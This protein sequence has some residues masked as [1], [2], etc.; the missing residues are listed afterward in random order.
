MF[1]ERRHS[2][3]F[4]PGLGKEL[5]AQVQYKRNVVPEMSPQW[6]REGEKKRKASS[7]VEASSV[8]AAKP[9]KLPR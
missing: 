7:E 4:F 8:L 5:A 3:G 2:E 1:F 6:A 9:Q